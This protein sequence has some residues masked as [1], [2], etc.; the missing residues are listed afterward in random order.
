MNIYQDITSMWRYGDVFSAED[1]SAGE[2]ISLAEGF[3]PIHEAPRTASR[4]G[5]SRL[6]IKDESQNPSG[7]FEDRGAAYTITKML[8]QGAKGIVLQS[9]GNA[10]ASFA[11]Y[12]ARAGLPCHVV[13]PRDILA[14]N[15]DQIRRSGADLTYLEDWSLADFACSRIVTATGYANVSTTNTPHRVIANQSLGYEIVEQCGRRMPDAIFLPASGGDSVLALKQAFDSICN[16]AL[17]P[18]LFISQY[19]GCAPLVAAFCA[20]LKHVMPS[21]SVEIS[22][23]MRTA[24]PR[25]GAQVLAAIRSSGGGAHAVSPALAGFFAS[26]CARDDGLGVGLE[27]GSALAFAAAAVVSGTLPK[28][29]TIL[30]V[31]T[32]GVSKVAPHFF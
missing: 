3:T 21:P 5:Y 22:G 6:L 30:V 14:V 16:E 29:S 31:N 8:V 17:S 18:Q 27:G 20:G 26:N 11:T 2:G 7:S 25:R 1:V 24:F 9:T 32:A 15:A 13:V 12:A 19:D 4:F 10:G 28:S 23:A